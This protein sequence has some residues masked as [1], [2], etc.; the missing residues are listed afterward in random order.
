MFLSSTHPTS[1]KVK[2]KAGEFIFH[3]VSKNA[4]AFNAASSQ[5]I[6][7]TNLFS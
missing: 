5:K 6:A 3:V 2:F 4:V 7:V 1:Q